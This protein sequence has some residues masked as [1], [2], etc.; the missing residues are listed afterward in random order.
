M[1]KI[2]LSKYPVIH[3]GN[4]YRVD[5]VKDHVCLGNYQWKVKVYKFVLK[6]IPFGRT[7]YKWKKVYTYESGWTNYNQWLGKYIELAKL[8]VIKYEELIKTKMELENR[9]NQGI[10]QWN[11]WDGNIR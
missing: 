4:E 1:I 8:A 11:E 10:K 5:I 7:K 2:E 6:T 3:N 9:N